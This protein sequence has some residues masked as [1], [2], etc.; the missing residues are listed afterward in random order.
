ME[1]CAV[2]IMDLIR[3]RRSIRKFTGD[4]V[5]ERSVEIILD[6][7]RWAPSGK[8]N[9]PWRFAVIRD[10]DLKNAISELT[11]SGSIIR[12]APVCIAVF[13]DN[14]VCYD[15]TKDVQA[16]GACIQN[17]LLAIHS[18]GLG[19]V[20]I[21]EILRNKEEVRRLLQA[22]ESFELMAVVAIGHPAVS[23]RGG[24]R[25]GIEEIVFLKK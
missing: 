12:G 23:P 21:G 6:A 4:E 24:S 15:R 16:I 9:Q 2:E 11:H 17:M 10:R 13:L 7:G 14:S 22:P 1:D 8:N 18:M 20:W 25:K 19:G 3:S 5:D